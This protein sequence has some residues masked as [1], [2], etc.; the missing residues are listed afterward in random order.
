MK[1]FLETSE[2]IAKG[3]GFS[4]FDGL[5]TAWICVFIAVTLINVFLYRRLS[6]SGKS[7]WRKAV[8]ILLVADELFKMTMLFIGDRYSPDYLALHLCSINIILIAVHAWKPSRTLSNFLFAICIP[9][10]LLAIF[11]PSWTKLPLDNFMHI[12][13]FTVHILLALY[14]IVLLAGGDLKPRLRDLPRCLLLLVILGLIALGANLIFD[15]NFMFL[16]SASKGNPL[17]WFKQNWG[18]HRY[19]FPVLMAA[20]LFLFY[21]PVA[22]IESAKTKRKRI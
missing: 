1:Y 14:P 13:S 9:A 12:H 5:H 11:F 3:V 17:Y 16:M 6:E 18:D 4:H 19:G 10:A 2:T 22:I 7:K 8:A 15:T 20:I 21:A